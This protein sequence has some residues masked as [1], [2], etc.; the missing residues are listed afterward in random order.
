VG[1]I[2][3][4]LIFSMALLQ[5]SPSALDLDLKTPRLNVMVGKPGF[6]PPK[7]YEGKTF[8][9]IALKDWRLNVSE[10]EYTAF[11][12]Y[13][14]TQPADQ[15]Y[16]LCFLPHSKR[17]LAVQPIRFDAADWFEKPDA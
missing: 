14:A 5:S 8:Y 1:A 4:G 2:I 15:D 10:A 7:T 17:I 16:L 3:V 13:A 12:A 11:S 9:E 6:M